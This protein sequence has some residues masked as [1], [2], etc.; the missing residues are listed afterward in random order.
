[1][2]AGAKRTCQMKREVH[3]ADGVRVLSVQQPWAWAIVEGYKRVENRT[4]TTR[5]RGPVLIHA[6]VTVRGPAI[7]YLRE[8]FRLQAPSRSEIDRGCIVGIA[9]LVDVVTRKNSKR[10]GR[11]FEGPYG[12]VFQRAVTLRRP[13]RVKS[14][15]GLYRPTPALLAR[16]N[17]QLPHKRRIRAGGR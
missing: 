17:A 11:W 5:H 7:E 12:L 2:G 4:W 10:F 8:E 14:Q 1:M 3:R 13:V 15:L 6:G 16:V 9:E